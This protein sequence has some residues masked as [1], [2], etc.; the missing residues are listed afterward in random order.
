MT[1]VARILASLFLFSVSFATSGQGTSASENLL[2]RKDISSYAGRDLVLT[3]RELEFPPSAQ[4]EKH[5]HPGPV[6]ACVLEGSLEVA[7]EGQEPK[8]YGP[9]Q[10]FSEE[11]HQL[12]LY[13]RNLSKT[14]PVRLISYILSRNG[15]PLTRREKQW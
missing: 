1:R 9:G 15:E 6:V 13:S 14:A 3:V 4:G 12:H 2:L 11:P 10:C 5:R 8:M 7:L